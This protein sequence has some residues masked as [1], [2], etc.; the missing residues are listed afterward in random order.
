MLRLGRGVSLGQ[1]EVISYGQDNMT[2][3]RFVAVTVD[4]NDEVD[5]FW[6]FLRSRGQD[7]SA[8]TLR[9]RCLGFTA[10]AAPAAFLSKS[11]LQLQEVKRDM[12]HSSLRAR[13]HQLN[14][15]V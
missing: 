5:G 6:R 4:T 12:Q 7:W 15:P 13:T 14:S 11:C 1:N 9:R 8:L 2:S 3:S 10:D